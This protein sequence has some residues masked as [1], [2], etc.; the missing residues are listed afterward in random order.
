MIR[1]GI[2]IFIACLLVL[3]FALYR[4]YISYEFAAFDDEIALQIKLDIKE[5]IGL[6]IIDYDVN[7]SKGSGGIS[8]ADK[9]MIK[10]DELLIYTLSK[11]DFN[12]LTNIENLSIQLKIV[13]KYVEPN[14]DNV[15]PDEYTIPID[16]IYLKGNYGEVY[17]ITISGDKRNGYEAVLKWIWL[18]KLKI[19]V[20]KLI[21]FIYCKQLLLLNNSYN[22]YDCFGRRRK[23]Y[24]VGRKN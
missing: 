5:D 4:W 24:D 7:G 10:H 19:R 12:N 17:F 9:T 16:T 23:L 3:S 1:K 18:I 6:I 21:C 13:T 11:S 20:W 8:N 15:Y 22:W 2:I 14:Y